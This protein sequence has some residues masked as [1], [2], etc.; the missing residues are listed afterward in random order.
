MNR[1]KLWFLG[2]IGIGVL[3]P[4]AAV[5]DDRPGSRDAAAPAPAGPM[6]AA[7]AAAEFRAPEGFHVTV[8]A[9]EPD[10]QNPIA[11]AWDPRGRLWVAENHTYSDQ[12]Q[13]FDLRQHDRVLIFEDKD[14]D[15]RFD[16]RTVFTEDVQMLASVELGFGG[17]WLLCPPR[18]LYLPDRDGDD[19]PDGPAQVVLD[20]FTVPSENYHTFANGLRWGP[21]GWLYGRCGASSP[22]QVGPPGTPDALRVPVRGG[23]WRYNTRHKRFEALAHGTTNPWGHDWNALGELFF[24]NTV[25]GHLWHMIPGA[26]FV[27]PHTIDPN[28]RAY[29]QIEQHADHWHFDHSKE[30][31]LGAPGAGDGVLGGGHAHSGVTIYLGDQ[32]PAEYHG[33]LLTLNFHG[34]RVNVE[35]L[36]RSGSGYIGHHQPDILFAPDPWFR[37]IDLSYGPDGGVFILDWSDIGECHERDGVHRASGR[38]YKVT[39]GT[40]GRSRSGDLSRLND[41][42]LIALHRH[43]SEWFVRQA[44][45]VLAG[46]AA[47]GEPLAKARNLLRDLFARESDPV[48]KLRALWSLHVTGGTDEAFLRSL[49]DHEHESIRA[50]AIRLLTDTLPLDSVFSQRIGT[51]VNLEPDLQLG[52][53]A[54]ARDDPSGLVR[55]VLASTLGR[56]PVKDRAGLARALLSHVEDA[57]DHNLPALIW[58]GLI[59]LAETDPAA[60]AALAAEC[61][62]GE[63]VCLI[64]RRLGE[65]VESRPEPLDFLLAAGATRPQD[66]RSQIVAGLTD[67]LAG[68]RKAKKPPAWDTFQT[69]CGAI[70]DP[71]LQAQVRA[72]NVVFGDGRALEEVRRLALD[73]KAELDARRAALRT[74]IENR[75]SDLRRICERLARVRFLNATAVRGLALFN[76]PAIGR[77][78]AQNYRSFHPSDRPAVLDTL[79]SRRAYARSLLEQIGAGKIPRS[80]L[81]PFHARQI[82][83][84][85]DADLARQ[86]SEVWGELRAST[87]ERRQRMRELKERLDPSTLARADRSHGRAI[88]DRVCGSCHKLYG[89]GGDIGPD[90]TG[91][92][93]DNLDY[94]LENIVDP[95]ASVSADFRM[96]VVA[97]NDG[98]VLNGLV[99][100]QTERTLTLQTQTEA[101]VLDR[102][103]IEGLRPSPASLMPDGLLDTLSATEIRDLIAYLS[104]HAQVPLPPGH[105]GGHAAGASRAEESAPARA[106]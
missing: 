34:R 52:F 1:E 57:S 16:R 14:A 64:A 5:S 42:E 88:Y 9:A 92:G 25:N 106:K 76:D 46:R 31:V 101:T 80:D 38:I 105:D 29:A 20:G 45:L 7:K 30:L 21:D 93:R 81:T 23:I 97:M 74:L 19:L 49:L 6:A 47:S 40:P 77:T 26:H 103:E 35:K 18:L 13:K 12:S 2:I 44:R 85:G 67:A 87:A 82:L 69:S 50:W 56:L 94:L 98:R 104:Q 73:E 95:S 91:S 90:L 71:M 41:D 10:V 61:R 8:F 27:R 15:G 32:W 96:V 100:R 24:I 84:S 58:T 89:N 62:L 11:M 99:K 102:S 54:M 66:V 78:L 33:A 53:Q 79:V 39:Y 22:G 65:D 3:W 86:L 51:N 48:R 36:E 55:L 75:P 17:V 60:L 63:V 70:A 72:L 28:A 4:C 37:G 59:P 68:Y 43:P 83:S